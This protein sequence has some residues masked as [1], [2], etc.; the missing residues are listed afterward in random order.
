[1]GAHILAIKDM[2]GLCKPYAAYELI[3]ALKNEVGIPIHFHT[4][5]TSGGQM[6]ALLKAVEAG[7]DIVDAA[8]APLGRAHLSAQ[9]QHAG[10]NV[11][12]FSPG[13]RSRHREARGDG[14]LLGGRAAILLRL[15]VDSADGDGGCLQ[16]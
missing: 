3:R 6:A 7:A 16:A 8:M 4:H 13:P 15:R 10:G 1:M 5:D 12:V 11:A 2:A 14:S 9:S